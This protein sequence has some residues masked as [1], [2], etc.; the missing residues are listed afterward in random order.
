MEFRSCCIT[1]ISN[2]CWLRST[3]TIG[4]PKRT[5]ISAL[6]CVSLLQLKCCCFFLVVDNLVR[7]DGRS[8]VWNSA[9]VTWRLFLVLYLVL[10]QTEFFT[11]YVENCCRSVPEQRCVS[12]GPWWLRSTLTIGYLKRIEYVHFCSYV[13]RLA[14]R[15]INIFLNCADLFGIVINI[16]ITRYSRIRGLW[17]FFHIMDLFKIENWKWYGIHAYNLLSSIVCDNLYCKDD[18]LYE[19]IFTLKSFAEVTRRSS[20]LTLIWTGPN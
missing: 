14:L 15:R 8:I 18:I 11:F 4:Y 7:F 20:Q 5:L 2:P 3:L 6:Q 17:R 9:L 16:N 12:V 19:K 13:L 1:T 10:G